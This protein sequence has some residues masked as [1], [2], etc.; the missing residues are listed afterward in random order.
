MD[1]DYGFR[2]AANGIVGYLVA[3]RVAAEV[4]TV[5]LTV[6]R[7]FVLMAGIKLYAPTLAGFK[8]LSSG[9]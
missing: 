9:S 4:E 7:C 6:D 8:Q 1:E 2:I 5:D 3:G